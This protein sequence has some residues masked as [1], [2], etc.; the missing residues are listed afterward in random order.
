MTS[1]VAIICFM[2]TMLLI[3]HSDNVGDLGHFALFDIM[4][5]FF[6]DINNII[7]L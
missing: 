1:L 4:K 3:G 2:D 6:S 7:I 5:G